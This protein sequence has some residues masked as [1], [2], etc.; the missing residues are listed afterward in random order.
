MFDAPEI[1]LVAPFGK[2]PI[3]NLKDISDPTSF[4]SLH[5]IFQI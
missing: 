5:G 4:L 2:P 3:N 1:G